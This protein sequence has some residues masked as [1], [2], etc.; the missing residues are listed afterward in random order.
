LTSVSGTDGVAPTYADA[1]DALACQ[2]PEDIAVVCRDGDTGEDWLA[3]LHLCA[4]SHW[5]A[6]EK[7]GQSWSQTHAPVP[8]MEKTRNA[9][10]SIVGVM[11]EREPTVRFTWG[12][13]FNDQLNHHPEPP[14]NTDSVLWN[15]RRLNHGDEEPFFLRVERQVIWG[16]PAVNAALFT[17]RVSHIPG[18][19]ILANRTHRKNLHSALRSMS[20]ESRQYKGLSDSREELLSCLSGHCPAE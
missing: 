8:G 4:P 5:V 3:S 9:A 18:S 12:V 6:E 13:E 19:A 11:I 16:L 2:V 1:I 10:R 15:R 20:A 14:P 7:I 17:I